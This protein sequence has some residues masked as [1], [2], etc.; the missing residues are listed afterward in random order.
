MK[1]SSINSFLDFSEMYLSCLIIKLTLIKELA[2]YSLEVS[3]SA[4]PIIA[5][6]AL[7]TAAAS[8]RSVLPRLI[9]TLVATSAATSI[10]HLGP[11]LI[12]S[13]TLRSRER[14]LPLCKLH[15]LG[16]NGLQL[17]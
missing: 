2:L 15:H 3:T 7:K 5:A 16:R 6:L 14:H 10:R 11:W 1:E 8:T 17:R 4:A 9:A 13:W 12:A